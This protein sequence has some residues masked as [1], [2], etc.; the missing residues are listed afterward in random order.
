MGDDASVAMDDA[1]I[2][3]N[4]RSRAAGDLRLLM[5]RL[6]RRATRQ[7]RGAAAVRGVVVG[8]VVAVLAIVFKSFL[9]FA[10]GDFGYVP[11]LAGIG[12]AAWFAGLSG[13]IVTG[14]LTGLGNVY[15]FTDPGSLI[16]SA[17]SEQ[18]RLVTYL[19][20]AGIIA[21]LIRSLRVERDELASVLHDQARL[22]SEIVVRDERLELVL[23]GS[24]TGIWEVD[25]HTGRSDWSDQVF[26][27][28]GFP[29]GAE[30]VDLIELVAPDHREEARAAVRAATVER[31]PFE[32]DVPLDRRDGTIGWAHLK[33]RTFYEGARADRIVGTCEDITDRIRLREERTA[34][35]AQE[36]HALEF[37]RA[38]IDVLSHE[39]RT[40]MTTIYAAAEM[41]GRPSSLDERTRTELLTDIRDETARLDGL[42]ENLLVL[43]RA[44]RGTLELAAEPVGL[45]RAI[46]RAVRAEAARW[47]AVTFTPQIPPDLPIVAG[48]EGYVAR[49]LANLLSNAGKY[50][51]PGGAVE[52]R[53]E[54]AG[55]EVLVRVLDHGVGIDVDPDQ[56]F[57]LFFR[58]PSAAKHASGSGVGLFVCVRLLEAMGGRIWAQPRDEGG[59]EFGFALRRFESAASSPSNTTARTVTPG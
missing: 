35:A 41:L 40:P 20:S 19:I 7:G 18:V 5:A 4:A 55:D 22:V 32:L 37:Q 16:P 44:Q 3:S 45:R 17:T 57:S 47:P 46:E 2:P 9:G 15:L 53:A 10:G 31:R 11:F 23:A 8:T 26:V 48:S 39:L 28:T 33:G 24:R 34:L 12:L 25:L 21:V 14:V 29:P 27:Q 50:S 54:S 42:I 49:I 30:P 38:F 59:A 58:A 51:R 43:S 13:G 6:E 1:Q 52:V 36:Q 56:L